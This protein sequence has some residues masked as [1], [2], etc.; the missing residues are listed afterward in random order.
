LMVEGR[1]RS[2]DAVS[3]EAGR[4]KAIVC[5]PVKLRQST[6]LPKVLNKRDYRFNRLAKRPAGS[7]GAKFCR[8]WNTN[9]LR[10]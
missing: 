1:G 6:F 5:R 4:I 9:A 3:K 8:R 2:R 7:H 10:K